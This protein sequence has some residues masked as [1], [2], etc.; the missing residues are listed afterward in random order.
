MDIRYNI[1]D[2]FR[3]PDGTIK[4]LDI[5]MYLHDGSPLL[6]K[7]LRIELGP[8]T[9]TFIPFESV[10]K[11][12]IQEWLMAESNKEGTDRLVEASQAIQAESQL[13]S[14]LPWGV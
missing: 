12:S 11:A 2:M 5:E 14:G 4:M 8:P 3:D 13:T 9:G 7:Q 6:N 10:T 1:I